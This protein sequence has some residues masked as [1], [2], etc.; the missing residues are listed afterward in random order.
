MS[1]ILLLILATILW[2]FWGIADKLALEQ[3]H[4]Y[5]IQWMYAVPYVILLP[6]F[7]GLAVR[8]QP[9]R[10]SQHRRLFLGSGS[11]QRFYFGAPAHVVRYA[12]PAHFSGRGCHLSVSAGNAVYRGAAEDGNHYANESGW[13]GTY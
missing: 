12:L 7:Y 5:T 3:A 6:V 1:P 11:Q 9:E 2:G 13:H 8:A 4:P 10:Q